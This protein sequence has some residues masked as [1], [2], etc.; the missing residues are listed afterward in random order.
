MVGTIQHVFLSLTSQSL[1]D[2][3]GRALIEVQLESIHAQP[4]SFP[5]EI[6]FL[7][8]DS[9]EVIFSSEEKEIVTY[10]G[11]E[12]N[13]L[14]SDFLNGPNMRV[15][16]DASDVV[17]GEFEVRPFFEEIMLYNSTDYLGECVQFRGYFN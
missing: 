9:S 5:L 15:E 11:A 12:G 6:L 3:G 8:K 1:S 10:S 7:S 16:L 13:Y 4:L 2:E 17:E 14:I